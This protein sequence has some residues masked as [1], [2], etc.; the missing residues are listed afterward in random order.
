VARAGGLTPAQDAVLGAVSA[1]LPAGPA[2]VALS[3]GADSAALAWAVTHVGAEARAVSVDHGLPGS[4]RL[5]EAAAAV[6]VRLGMAHRVIPVR[7]EGTSE[8][9]L[10]VARL[11]ALEASREPGEVVLTAHTADDQAETMLGNL[12]RGAGPA[13][14]AGIPYRRGVFV[15][16]L[17]GVPRE[18]TRRAA[19]EAGMP[20]VDDPANTDPSIWRNRIRTDTLPH[21]AEEYNPAVRDALVRAAALIGADD[22]YLEERADAVAVR[23][24]EEAVVVPASV[25]VTLPEPIASRVVRRALRTH[26]HPYPGDADDVAAVL[27]TAATGVTASLTGGLLS[28]L[29]RGLVAIHPAEPV[30]PPDPVPLATEGVTEFGVWRIRP[31]DRPGIGAATA[32][33]PV[34]EGAV[35]RAPRP[36][37]RIAIGGGGHKSV[38]DAL[39]EAGVPARMR[40]RWPLVAAGDTIGWIVGVRAAPAAGGGRIVTLKATRERR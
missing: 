28:T 4:A 26:L 8:T 34:A 23:R 17:L 32:A 36:G 38:A 1:S 9:A 3:G 24:D 31:A 15:R 16:P 39:G 27:R 11:E 25:L 30:S 2:V 40:P 14:V 37:D 13:G 29:E 20:F 19:A 6:A 35:V 5:M 18:V 33:V 22:R 10:R 21:L 12:V 7:A